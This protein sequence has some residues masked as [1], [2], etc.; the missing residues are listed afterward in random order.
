MASMKEIRLIQ[1]RIDENLSKINKTVDAGFYPEE[2]S[3]FCRTIA[4]L[5]SEIEYDVQKIAVLSSQLTQKES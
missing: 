4:A 5:T 1:Y 3:Q 2:Y